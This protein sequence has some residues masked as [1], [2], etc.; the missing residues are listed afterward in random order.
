MLFRISYFA[1]LNRAWSLMSFR[2]RFGEGGIFEQRAELSELEGNFGAGFL[3]KRDY[4]SQGL[5]LPR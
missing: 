3:V 1:V 5:F 4:Y 2:G